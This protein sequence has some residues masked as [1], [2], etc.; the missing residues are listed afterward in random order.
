MGAH[1]GWVRWHDAVASTVPLTMIVAR[2]SA[3]SRD[4]NGRCAGQRE[5]PG[6]LRTP[7]N[8]VNEG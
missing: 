8:H 3:L 4:R 2:P 1:K 5:T 6:R 7:R